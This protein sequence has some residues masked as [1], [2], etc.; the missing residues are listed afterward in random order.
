EKEADAPGKGIHVHACINGSL[1][2]GDTIAESE[3]NLLSS[4]RT[5]LADVIAADGD[6]VPIRQ[7]FRAVCKRIRH[8]THAGSRWIDISSA[9]GVFLQDVVLDGAT[10]LAG[11]GTALLSHDLIHEQ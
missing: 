11:I 3:G 10:K 9:S 2:I 8:Q 7:M 1:H 4:T 6:G 5:C